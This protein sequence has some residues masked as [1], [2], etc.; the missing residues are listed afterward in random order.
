MF[1]SKNARN[2]VAAAIV[3]MLAVG[4][5][6]AAQAA[7]P[8][9]ADGLVGAIPAKSLFCIRINNFDGTLDAANEFLKDLMPPSFDAKKAVFSRLG[10]VLSDNDLK[11]INKKGNIAVFGVEVPAEPAAA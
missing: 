9:A 10:S 2:A 4:N 11:G 5:V 3:V 6:W 7:R 1:N 8:R